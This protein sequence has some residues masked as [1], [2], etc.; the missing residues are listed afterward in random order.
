MVLTTNYDTF[1]EQCYDNA[2][3]S[4][5]IHVGNRGLFEKTDDY[6]ELYKI[7]GSV[8]DVNTICIT[9]EDY[10]KNEKKSALV[11]AKIL[12]NLTESPIIFL[13]YSLT[14]RNVQNILNSFVENAPFDI[15]Q[16]ASRIGVVEFDEG[17]TDFNEAER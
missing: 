9:K 10:Q 15:S 8:K 13:G 14:D 17:N 5:Q 1:I 12:S 3:T 11:D 16:A 7:H 2:N 6:G 4:V